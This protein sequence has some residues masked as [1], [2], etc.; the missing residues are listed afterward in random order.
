MI[1]EQ[2]VAKGFLLQKSREIP[3]KG[4]LGDINRQYNKLFGGFLFEID[5]KGFELNL[6]I[7]LL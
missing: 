2:V 1:V 4:Q 6:K 5:V 3:E 7:N